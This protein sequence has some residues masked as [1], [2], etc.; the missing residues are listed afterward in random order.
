VNKMHG[1]TYGTEVAANYDLASWLRLRGSYSWVRVQLHRDASIPGPRVERE[2]GGTPKH[3]FNLHS[4]LRLRPGL[5]LDT[6]LYYVGER[7]RQRKAQFTR[8]DT[9][10][11]W[12][13]TEGLEASIA[14]Q[15][16]LPDQHGEFGTSD[17][18]QIKRSFYTKWTWSF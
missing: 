7:P 9:R 14:V 12:R 17:P 1:E 13:L 4:Y 18:F 6:F 15:N 8:L 2:E 3:Q 5:T 16:L 11:A 10:L